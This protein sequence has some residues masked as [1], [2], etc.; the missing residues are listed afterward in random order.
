M[1]S[2]V[3]LFLAAAVV[4]F[5]VVWALRSAR[6]AARLAVED[7][8][9]DAP[10]LPAMPVLQIERPAPPGPAA[11]L[12]AATDR[13][14]LVP[15]AGVSPRQEDRALPAG[16]GGSLVALLGVP[17]VVGPEAPAPRPS[18]S[19]LPLLRGEASSPFDGPGLE[20]GAPEVAEVQP[21]AL[22]PAD[23]QPDR[24]PPSS[25]LP[26]RAGLGLLAAGGWW[27]LGPRGDI[28]AAVHGALAGT[29]GATVWVLV[30]MLGDARGR[31]QQARFEAELLAALD[32]LP[33]WLARG[34]GPETAIAELAAGAHGPGGPL[35]E[36]A[37]RVLADWWP[38]PE[39]P[40]A[41]VAARTR[42]GAEWAR[43]LFALD[44]AARTGQDPARLLAHTAASLRE[45]VETGA[46][47][48]GTPGPGWALAIAIGVVAIAAAIGMSL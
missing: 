25:G 48:G 35:Q 26:W 10:P 1:N 39:R 7:P 14:P 44:E 21:R 9:V 19:D 42:R 47:P 46:D 4:L 20:L 43:V 45:R 32:E 12:L 30:G 2:L 22:P 18:A 24:A 11:P 8:P 31:G 41:F 33:A 3:A 27:W 34:V 5:S 38:E 36:E 29:A 17:E 15:I 16:T 13:A 6:R 23:V 40:S 37:R 28:P